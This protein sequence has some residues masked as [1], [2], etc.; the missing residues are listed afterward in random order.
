MEFT[1]IVTGIRLFNKDCQKG[2]EGID[3]RK[4]II[5]FWTFLLI[6]TLK[7]IF[8]FPVPVILVQAVQAT[9]ERIN[10]TKEF[11]KNRINRLTISL[12]R[13]YQLN[14]IGENEPE[15]ALPSGFRKDQLEQLKRIL[16]LMRQHDLYIK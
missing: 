4:E 14:E 1:R 11:L 15:V 8:F 10:N 5:K 12:E 7:Y 6:K 13:A 9:K 2:G 3:D 16:I